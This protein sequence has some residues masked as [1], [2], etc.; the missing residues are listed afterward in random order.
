MPIYK[1]NYRFFSKAHLINCFSSDNTFLAIFIQITDTKALLHLK[2][3]FKVCQG[4]ELSNLKIPAVAHHQLGLG[5]GLG[6]LK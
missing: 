4:L 3:G 2:I 6:L 5:L 1:T